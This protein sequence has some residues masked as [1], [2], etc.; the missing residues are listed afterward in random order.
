MSY[1]GDAN[2]KPLLFRVNKH[3]YHTDKRLNWSDNNSELF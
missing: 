2:S 1:T 3:M